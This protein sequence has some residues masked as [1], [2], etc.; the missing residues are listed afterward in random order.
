MEKPTVRVKIKDG[1][2]ESSYCTVSQY[3]LDSGPTGRGA[4]LVCAYLLIFRECINSIY[5]TC[6]IAQEPFESSFDLSANPH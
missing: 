5:D 6:E 3:P 4:L 2:A 1:G